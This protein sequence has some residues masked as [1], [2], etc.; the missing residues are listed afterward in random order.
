MDEKMRQALGRRDRPKV[1]DN[2]K[3]I[4]VEK[5]I[6]EKVT[7]IVEKKMREYSTDLSTSDNLDSQ[8]LS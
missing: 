7:K 2:Q 3:I 5:S 1:E 4:Y 8:T 6:E